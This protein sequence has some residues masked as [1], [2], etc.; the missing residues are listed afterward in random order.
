MH[1]KD[2][3]RT[4]P[5]DLIGPLSRRYKSSAKQ[6]GTKAVECAAGPLESIHDVKRSDGFSMEDVVMEM[7]LIQVAG[8][9]KIEKP[10]VSRARC[11]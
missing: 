11:K 2:T 9:A 1:S 8:S 4:E 5:S 10:T 7:R 6:S 3:R